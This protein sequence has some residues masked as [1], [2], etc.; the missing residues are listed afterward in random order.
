MNTAQ[1]QAREIQVTRSDPAHQAYVML[2]WGFVAL[3][4]IAGIDKFAH[5]L[6]NWDAYLAP[7]MTR[8]LGGYSHTFMLAV[9]IVEMLAGLLVALKPKVGGWVVAGWLGAIILNLLYSGRYFD[10][11]LRDFGLFL[12]ALALARLSAT[13]DHQLEHRA[14]R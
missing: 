6:T 3:P 14:A 11:A 1:P 7:Q 4:V 8:L 5:L 13:Y 10:V 12:A 2:H 9:G